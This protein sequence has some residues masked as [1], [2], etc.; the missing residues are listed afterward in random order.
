MGWSGKGRKANR[1]VLKVTVVEAERI[2]DMRPH[3]RADHADQ[4]TSGCPGTSPESSSWPA[5]HDA[6]H[7]VPQQRKSAR[8]KAWLPLILALSWML[9]TFGAFW[10]GGL[11][12][13]VPNPGR[14]C[15]FVL[16]A[17]GLF[18]L[19]YAARVL[20][21]P[22]GQPTAVTP[23]RAARI[24]HLVLVGAG[25]YTVLSIIRLATLGA[26]GPGNVWSSVQD[27][28]AAYLHKLQAYDQGVGQGNPI[29]SLL[30]L[31]GVCGTTLA[32][33]LVVY[34]RH[35][36]WLA[37][38]AGLLG[39]I[40]NV[41]Y[42]L[43]I[44]TLKGLGDVAVMLAAGLLVL[45]AAPQRRA[46]SRR[47]TAL[48]VGAAIAAAF[49]AYMVFSQAART[50]E[51]GTSDL[52][53]PSPAVASLA[54][55]RVADGLAALVFYPTHGYLGLAYN[56]QAPFEW[57]RGLGSAPAAAA[58][59]EERLGAD[60]LTNTSYPER[61]ESMTGW[62][63]ELYWATAY[64]WLASDLTFPGAALFM[65]LVGWLFARVWLEAAFSRRALPLLLFAQLWIFIAYVPANNQLGMSP[66][67]VAGVVTL[68]VLL[69]CR[70]Q[71][72]AARK[73]AG[74]RA[75]A[76][77]ADRRGRPGTRAVSARVPVA[78]PQGPR[79]QALTQQICLPWPTGFASSSTCSPPAADT[80]PTPG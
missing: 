72:R 78:S 77:G 47:R 13:Q 79:G 26:T 1:K 31:L 67:S 48:T 23:T 76:V 66:E 53:K 37:R 38:A 33:L 43:Y 17:T 27:P 49:T 51:F 52:V 68:M 39:L 60:A 35:L 58:L 57:S 63:A 80:A 44:G 19:G 18:A 20:R 32:P 2:S 56:L 41:T 55:P 64:P 11:G 7:A 16:S 73:S 24:R 12:Q 29:L 25:Y 62:S 59:A 10:L 15:A 36:P 5:R 61:T 50:S 46:R 9:G 14:L 34:W 71:T 3:P 42:Y 4:G 69:L 75:P 45:A 65:A 40:L 28:A 74:V 22:G 30:A 21:V 70:P 6:S 54:G 8:L